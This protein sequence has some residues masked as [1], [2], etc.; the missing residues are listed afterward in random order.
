[1]PDKPSSNV[2]ALNQLVPSPTR[3][4]DAMSG[5]N[6]AGA[7]MRIITVHPDTTFSEIVEFGG[8]TDRAAT[9]VGEV[10][11]AGVVI[12]SAVG[13][14]AYAADKKVVVQFND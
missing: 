3:L 11:P 13:I 14:T 12:E 4:D 6:G 2:V 9:F 10:L 1:M 7:I 5:L 8:G